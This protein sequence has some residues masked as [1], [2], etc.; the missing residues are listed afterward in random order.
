M[1]IKRSTYQSNDTLEEFYTSDRWTDVLKRIAD[2]MLMLVQMI[3]DLFVKT[4]LVA[5]TSHQ[6][7]CI[8]NADNEI[9]NALI[10]ITGSYLEEYY[11]EYKVPAHKSPWKDAWMRGK[12]ENLEEL[13]HYLIKAMIET[14][15]WNDNEELQI[16]AKQHL[17]I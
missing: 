16:L 10:I 1:P 7:L 9:L 2:N 3:N 11:I 8:Q 6:R 4:E 5:F 17:K 12:A 14:E 15:N 13:K